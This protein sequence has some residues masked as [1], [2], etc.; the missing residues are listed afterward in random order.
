[1]ANNIN[2]N[3]PNAVVAKTTVSFVAAGINSTNTEII[4][5]VE[6]PLKS[7]VPGRAINGISGF[8]VNKGYYLV[9]KIDFD[10]ESVVVPPLVV[11]NTLLDGLAAYWAFEDASGNF[12]DATSNNLDLSR[13][14]AVATDAGGKIGN[15]AAMDDLEALSG[16]T[17]S[18]FSTHVT[19]GITIAGWF[20]PQNVG[21]AHSYFGKW[22]PTGGNEKEYLCDGNN[23]IIELVVHDNANNDVFVSTAFVPDGTFKFICARISNTQI[24][25]SINNASPV[26]AALTNPPKRLTTATFYV[27]QIPEGNYLKGSVDELGMWHRVLTDS[28]VTELYNAGVGKTY[29]FA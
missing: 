4:Y 22:G 14:G 23:S 26:T 15:C 8:E 16:G 5:L 7:Y 1:M 10:L 9:A 3:A 12:Q 21:S 17:N 13:V 29:P 11:T 28:E 2:G 27:G 19:N 6:D 24:S 25:L 20:A 18:L